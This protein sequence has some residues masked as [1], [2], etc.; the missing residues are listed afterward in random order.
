MSTRCDFPNCHGVLDIEKN[1][2]QV[3]DMDNFIKTLIGKY[4]VYCW[5][6]I[7][8]IVKEYVKKEHK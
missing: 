1:S 3:Y 4:H 5:N 8:K 7:A 2:I 6:K